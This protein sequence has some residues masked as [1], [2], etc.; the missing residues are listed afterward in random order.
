[1]FK[2]YIVDKY[3]FGCCFLLLLSLLFSSNGKIKS[4]AYSQGMDTNGRRPT[5][6]ITARN[7]G[8]KLRK[9]LFR[10]DLRSV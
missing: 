6:L 8:K 2:L 10:S 3:F 7:S 9:L 5:E 1:M 4:L